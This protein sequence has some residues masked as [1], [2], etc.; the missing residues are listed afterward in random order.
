MGPGGRVA[1][2]VGPGVPGGEA[3]TLGVSSEGIGPRLEV[4]RSVCAGV[5]MAV[6]RRLEVGVA[7]GAEHAATRAMSSQV[8]VRR[9]VKVIS[10][11]VREGRAITV[12]S[13]EDVH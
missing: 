9:W 11:E 3:G 5:V 10:S 7:D 6:G 13:V 2:G 8:S 4:G 12:H 1:G